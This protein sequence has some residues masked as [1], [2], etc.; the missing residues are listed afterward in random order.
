MAKDGINRGFFFLFRIG[1]ILILIV[2]WLDIYLSVAG[3]S[4]NRNNKSYNINT[5]NPDGFTERGEVLRII[6]DHG[7]S[8]QRNFLRL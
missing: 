5:A 2:G 8:Y 7:Y 4:G 1:S 6:A 3:L